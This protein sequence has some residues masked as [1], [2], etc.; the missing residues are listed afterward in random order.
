MAVDFVAP[1]IVNGEIEILI[2]DTDVVEKLEFWDN[3]S[4]LFALGQ[5]L[6]MNAVRIFM[7]KTWNFVAMPELY[8]N[9]E[10]Y[11]VLRFKNNEDKEKIMEQGP[12]F[13]YGKPIFLRYWTTDFEIKEDLLHVLPLWITLPNLPLHLGGEKSISKITSA[14]GKPI[15]TDKCTAK[16]LRIS[17]ARV[18]VEV[19]ITQKMRDKVC[20]KD[21]NGRILEQKIEYEWKPVYCQSCLRI[22]H[23]CTLKKNAQQKPPPTKLWKPINSNKPMEETQVIDNI[24]P[25]DIQNNA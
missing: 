3:A 2:E 14:V 17:Y 13:I 20:I 10:G 24:Q 25:E 16:K 6:S 4:I 22:S 18:L 21:H 11:F 9:D 12:Y 15:T 5:N 7:E 1:N 8:Y 19:D 23:D